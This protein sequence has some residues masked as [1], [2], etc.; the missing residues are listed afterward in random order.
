MTIRFF[1]VFFTTNLVVT[2]QIFD[3]DEDEIL[4]SVKRASESQLKTS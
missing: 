1:S 2:L 4:V 3:K